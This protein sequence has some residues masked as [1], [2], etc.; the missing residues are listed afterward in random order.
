[1]AGSPEAATAPATAA[2]AKT[3]ERLS[4][5]LVTTSGPTSTIRSLLRA[6]ARAVSSV[7]VALLMPTTAIRSRRRAE[8][9][10]TLSRSFCWTVWSA[11]SQ[12][13][14]CT[15]SAASRAAKAAA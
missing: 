9:F 15:F 2:A 8:A 1:M 7:V 6:V 14:T 5:P 10:S 3:P 12:T 13:T 11:L 4:P